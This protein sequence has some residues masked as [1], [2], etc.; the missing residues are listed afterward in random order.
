MICETERAMLV[1]AKKLYAEGRISQDTL[2]GIAEEYFSALENER[3]R[4]TRV[5]GK[6]LRLPR[7]AHHLICITDDLVTEAPA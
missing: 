7:D 3:A 4:G 6:L 2:Y 1:T 5:G